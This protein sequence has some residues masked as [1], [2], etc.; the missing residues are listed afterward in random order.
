[1]TQI[2]FVSPEFEEEKVELAI[3]VGGLDEV[4]VLELAALLGGGTLGLMFPIQ[5]ETDFLGD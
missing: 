2:L 5:V 4:P 1:M 3:R